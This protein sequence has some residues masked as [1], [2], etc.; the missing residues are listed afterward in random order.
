MA[1]KCLSIIDSKKKVTFDSIKELYDIAM[2]LNLPEDFYNYEKILQ[3]YRNVSDLIDSSLEFFKMADD[4]ELGQ[5]VATVQD[6]NSLPGDD[7]ISG[8]DPQNGSFRTEFYRKTALK[9][10]YS[11]TVELFEKLD[12]SFVSFD[13]DIE[14]VKSHIGKYD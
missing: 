2:E 10:D 8:M 6:P 9:Y 12:S 7:D 4:F 3:I 5:E 14:I 13:K 1:E 11:R